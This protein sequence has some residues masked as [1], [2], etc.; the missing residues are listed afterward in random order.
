[1]TSCSSTTVRSAAF[2]PVT[3]GSVVRPLP[4]DCDDSGR[5]EVAVKLAHPATIYAISSYRTGPRFPH[6]RF[7]DDVW[8]HLGKVCERLD[9]GE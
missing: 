4:A 3:C 8:P 6:C 7:P 1:M 9:E 2:R 5:L